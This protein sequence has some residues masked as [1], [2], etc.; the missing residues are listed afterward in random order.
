VICLR[1]LSITS[2]FHGTSKKIGSVC[3]AVL[4][5]SIYSVFEYWQTSRFAHPTGHCIDSPVPAFRLPKAPTSCTC[6]YTC[7]PFSTNVYLCCVCTLLAC[8]CAYNLSS[9]PCSICVKWRMA[10]RSHEKRKIPIFGPYWGPPQF[11]AT[12][13]IP[14]APWSYQ[15]IWRRLSQPFPIYKRTDR[16]TSNA[17]AADYCSWWSFSVG[18]CLCIMLV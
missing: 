15:K 11:F 16:H 5:L 10:G 7:R 18:I 4:P 13:T 3:A 1:P 8:V 9:A 17:W 12:K 6:V 2:S 14:G